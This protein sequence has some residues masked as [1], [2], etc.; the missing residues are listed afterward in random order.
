MTA[1]QANKETD[2]M[3]QDDH[4]RMTGP[5]PKH[6]PDVSPHSLVEPHI[7]EEV[8]MEEL[9]APPSNLHEEMFSS[10]S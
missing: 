6:V 1:L 2:N 9:H 4:T 7:I 8:D 3:H 10:N 5:R